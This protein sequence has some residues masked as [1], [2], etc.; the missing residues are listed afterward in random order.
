MRFRILFLILAIGSLS[1]GQETCPELL[2]GA[3]TRLRQ[4]IGT[5]AADELKGRE[6]GT[7]GIMMAAEYILEE[8]KKLNLVPFMDDDYKQKFTIPVQVQFGKGNT[9]SVG[10]DEYQL[11]SD[12]YPTKYSAN[13]TVEGETVFVGYGIVAP[14]KDYDDYKKLSS[15]KL[16]DK[17]FVMDISAPD[18]IHP[19]S[20]YLKY[21]DLGERILLAKKKGAK[22]IVLINN[23]GSANDVSP[24][25]TSIH[26]KGIP[27]IFISNKDLAKSIGKKKKVALSTQL[28][29]KTVDAY[30]LIGFLNNKAQQTIVIGA[31]YDHLGMGTEGSLAA[32]NEPQIHNGADDNASGV[33]GMLELARNIASGDSTWKAYNYVFAAFSGEEKG[34]LGSAYFTDN[35]PNISHMFKYMLNL[36]MVGRLEDN[37]LAVSGIG[38]SDAWELVSEKF[39]CGDLRIKGSSSGVGPSDH[40]NFYYKDI[41]ALHFFTGTHMDYHK[42]TDDV[43]KINFEG[44]EMVIRYILGLIQASIPV[45]EFMFTPTVEESRTAP[46]FNV[47]L[48]VM[49]DYMYEGEGMRIDGVTQ[50]RTADN[51]GLIAGDIVTQLGDV[52]VVDM[53][54]YMKALGQ[55][56]KGD[57]STIEYTRDGEKMSAQVKF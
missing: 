36:D 40:T 16:K 1:F 53:M 12:F 3:Q 2:K 42:P 56:K 10:G 27:V 43:D 24:K 44:E 21:H 52:K 45:K 28:T 37:L 57:E 51:A 46:S 5:L 47:T 50:G 34:L 25:F 26:S 33:A 38:T 32:T 6:P 29:P 54:S 55:Y 15:K 17:V 31:H 39:S 23:E 19:H 49:P 8:F 18:G 7:R 13:E 4:D 14:E 11:Y 22:A 48:G 20:E 9:L 30:N 41:P 35:V